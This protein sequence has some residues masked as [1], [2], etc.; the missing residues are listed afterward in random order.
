[1][2]LTPTQKFYLE[3]SIKTGIPIHQIKGQA[4]SDLKWRLSHEGLPEG[5]YANLPPSDIANAHFESDFGRRMLMSKLG[6]EHNQRELTKIAEDKKNQRFDPIPVQ[7]ATHAFANSLKGVDSK[8]E[9]EL[10][11]QEERKPLAEVH[12]G[13]ASWG[14]NRPGDRIYVEQPR[15]GD[16]KFEEHI[17][18]AVLA[19][20]KSQ[21]EVDRQK[22]LYQF[23]VRKGI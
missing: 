10:A 7:N 16:P 19:A 20:E 14:Y 18:E 4:D 2:G 11:A 8:I 15:A 1:M 22:M 21:C 5:D 23:A 17:D 3:L 9:Q 6:H 12:S 13:N